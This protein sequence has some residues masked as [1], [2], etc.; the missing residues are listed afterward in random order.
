M[1]LH[2]LFLLRQKAALRP[3]PAASS[4]TGFFLFDNGFFL[5]IA[6]NSRRKFGGRAGLK[7]KAE[8]KA[9]N[10]RNT[11]ADKVQS[12]NALENV[13]QPRAGRTCRWKTRHSLA[14]AKY[15]VGKVNKASRQRNMSSEKRTKPRASEI[16]RWK[17]EQSLAP[18]K[19]VFGK[20]NNASRK[21]AVIFVSAI[22]PGLACHLHALAAGFGNP[23]GT[24]SRK[25]LYP[26]I[27]SVGCISIPLPLS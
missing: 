10:G 22:S 12:H 3:T 6:R 5:P 14:P 2:E 11:P 15:V 16:C 26:A 18:A 1:C 21:S 9:K 19:H 7:A 8:A 17:S 25:A 4:I 13:T 23:T 27:Y 24:N 20:T